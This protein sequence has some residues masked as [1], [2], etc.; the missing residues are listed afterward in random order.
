MEEGDG[1]W[2]RRFGG[3]EGRRQ[4]RREGNTRV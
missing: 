2:K 1:R 4:A 3:Q